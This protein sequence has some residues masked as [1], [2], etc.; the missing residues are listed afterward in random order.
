VTVTVDVPPAAEVP[1][2]SV[3]VLAPVGAR[4]TEGR[5]YTTRQTG[6]GEADTAAEAALR[7]DGD[8]AG[9]TAALGN[10]E[11][12]GRCREA[13]VRHG[14]HK[15]DRGGMGQTAGGTVTVTVAVPAVTE[16]PAAQVSEYSFL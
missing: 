10:A 12:A 3:R 1:A 9:A 16:V 7:T 2:A 4:R 5:S 14:N 8:G 13:E 6:C 15:A 11:A